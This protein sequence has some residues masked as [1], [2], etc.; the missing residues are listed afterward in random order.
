MALAEMFKSFL[1]QQSLLHRSVVLY[2][3]SVLFISWKNMQQISIDPIQCFPQGFLRLWWM[4]LG[5]S[6]GVQGT[7]SPGTKFYFLTLN[8]DLVHFEIKFKRLE[9]K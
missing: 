3:R 5:P 2:V 4:A 8:L 9:H 6:I 7:S 1:K